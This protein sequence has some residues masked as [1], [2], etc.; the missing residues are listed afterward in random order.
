MART[1]ADRFRGR[2]RGLADEL[3]AA[4][5]QPP[6]R[7]C[8]SD[9]GDPAVVVAV[10]AVRVVEVAVDQV[11]HVV[12]VRHGFVAAARPV[13]VAAVVGAAGV[14]GRA[15]G[16]V[17]APDGEDVLVDVVA[18]GVVQAAVVEVVHMA[19]VPDGRVAAGGA[20]P[21]VVPGVRVAGH[22]VPPVAG[23]RGVVQGA[24]D[25]LGDVAVGERVVDV[26]AH[27]APRDGPTPSLDLPESS[28]PSPRGER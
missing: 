18:V 24:G 26:L 3:A 23:V 22:R 2:P 7:P 12:A 10:R 13:P 6:G 4:R 16:R 1:E 21:V 14:V 25:Q 20:V 11:V 19:V 9:Q 8:A 15:V 5:T 27:T 17:R 28:H